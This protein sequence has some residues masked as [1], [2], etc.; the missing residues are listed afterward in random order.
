ML[1][2]QGETEWET[3]T[4]HPK[5][6]ITWFKY[7]NS[8]KYYEERGCTFEIIPLKKNFMSHLVQGVKVRVIWPEDHTES[9]KE[10]LA[11]YHKQFWDFI[12]EIHYDTYPYSRNKRTKA[13]RLFFMGYDISHF[14]GLYYWAL[15]PEDFKPKEWVEHLNKVLETL[16]T[17]VNSIHD[18]LIMFILS[19]MDHKAALLEALSYFLKNEDRI[20][21]YDF[22]R[23]LKEWERNLSNN[24]TLVNDIVEEALN[25][26]N[27]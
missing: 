8:H 22:K 2:W 11:A 13:H 26:E 10:P 12:S 7:P 18:F 25:A 24:S 1:E 17:E 27:I 4:Y 6:F 21:I 3:I 15:N 5:P 9:Y 23:H 20:D 14:L 19:F 16:K